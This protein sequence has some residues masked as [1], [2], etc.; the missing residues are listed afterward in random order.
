M[1]LGVVGGGVA[2]ALA[3]KA[4]AIEASVGRPVRL[5]AALVQHPRKRRREADTNQERFEY[6]E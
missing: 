1:G 6:A 3:D 5:T 2:R 4:D